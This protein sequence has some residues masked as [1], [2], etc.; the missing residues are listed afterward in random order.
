MKHTKKLLT[1]LSCALVLS[2]CGKGNVAPHQ[3]GVSTQ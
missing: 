2:G 1:V 3:I